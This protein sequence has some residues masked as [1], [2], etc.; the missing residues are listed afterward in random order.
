MAAVE[1]QRHG[2]MGIGRA[3]ML[4]ADILRALGIDPVTTNVVSFRLEFDVH[5]LPILEMKTLVIREPE[6]IEE[7]F[8]KFTL[9]PKDSSKE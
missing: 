4:G 3:S 7:V 2:Y 8:S 6:Q 9:V 1:Y 5:G